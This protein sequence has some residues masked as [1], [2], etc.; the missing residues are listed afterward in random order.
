MLCSV[1]AILQPGDSSGTYY[2]HGEKSVVV[3]DFK[4]IPLAALNSKL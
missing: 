1:S 4:E 2:V 3:F